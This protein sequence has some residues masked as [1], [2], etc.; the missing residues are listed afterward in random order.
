[1]AI[2]LDNEFIYLA[3]QS[4]RRSELLRQLRVQFRIIRVQVDESVR[5]GEAPADCVQRLANDKAHA[6]LGILG[7]DRRLA[8]LAADTLVVV[9]DRILGKPVDRSEGLAMLALL[10]GRSHQVL[11]AV[12]LWHAGRM[13][14]ALSV[15]MV[16]FRVISVEEGEHYWQTG[17][18]LGK[19]GGYAIQGRA[20][21]FVERLEGSYTGVMGLPLFETGAL[22]YAAG[23]RIL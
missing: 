5:P 12:S 15:S 4:P 14:C 2:A 9:D 3:S 19:A 17:E 10:S 22:L 20:A 11:S 13:Q 23:L 7:D 1:M 18:P 21:L 8:I 6:A 16:T